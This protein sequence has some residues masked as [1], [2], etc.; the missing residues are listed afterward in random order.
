MAHAIPHPTSPRLDGNRIAANAGAIAINAALL[1]LLLIPLTTSEQH[2]PIIDKAPEFRWIVRPR[3]VDPPRPIEVPVVRRTSAQPPAAVIPQPRIESPPIPVLVDSLP[4]DPVVQATEATQ[5]GNLPA[6]TIGTSQPMPGARLQS[7]SAPSP[8][9]PRE[10]WR[11]RLSGTVMLEILVGVD[12]KPLDVTVL[13]SSG[14]RVLDQAARRIV[15]SQWTFEPAMQNGRPVQAR[16]RVPIEF[17][18]D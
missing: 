4:G 11:D 8:P 7:L 14:H 6:E 1:L 12:G 13:R 2:R 9:Y 16:G 5:P 3:P 10:A 15:L 18:L 17:K